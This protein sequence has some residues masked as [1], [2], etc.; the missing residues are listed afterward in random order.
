MSYSNCC[1]MHCITCSHVAVEWCKPT[2]QTCRKSQQADSTGGGGTIMI[3]LTADS[4]RSNEYNC[5]RLIIGQSVDVNG[6]IQYSF[7]SI[8][9][10]HI[11]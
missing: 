9:R 4:A 5:V 6:S 10:M 11:S 1:I 7:P 2:A 8:Q 3:Y